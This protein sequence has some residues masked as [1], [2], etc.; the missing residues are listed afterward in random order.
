LI[1]SAISTRPRRPTVAARQS[2][3]L[4]A[5]GNGSSY[6][7]PIPENPVFTVRNPHHADYDLHHRVL[8]GT[9]IKGCVAHGVRFGRSDFTAMR[10]QAAQLIRI[11]FKYCC[12]SGTVFYDCSLKRCSFYACALVDAPFCKVHFDKVHVEDCTVE[13]P[14][15]HDCTMEQLI[16][17][18]C[19]FP[20]DSEQLL[21]A[22]LGPGTQFLLCEFGPASAAVGAS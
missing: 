16:F 19:R 6:F 8:V 1:S 17:D 10:W 13:N 5:C 20:N 11:Q 15:F 22:S 12:L 21:R 18:R 14:V 7:P 3:S 2:T 9:R 4:V